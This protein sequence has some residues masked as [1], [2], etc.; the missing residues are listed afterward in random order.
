M[1]TYSQ[2]GKVNKILFVIADYPDKRQDFF[3]KWMSPR[4]REYAEIH[5]FEYRE[6]L[7]L[8]REQDGKF[9]RNNPTWLKFKIVK[10]WIESGELRKGDVISHIDAD[11]CIFDKSKSFETTKSF[12]YAIDSCNTHCMGAYTLRVDDWSI[13]MLNT[14]LSN[15]LYEKCKEE[16]HWKAF[17]EQA[18]WYTMSGIIPHS[19][20][21][22]NSMKNNGFHSSPTKNLKYSLKELE[23]HVEVFPT[24]WNV[25]HVAG[26]GFNDYFMIPTH[27]KDTV[28][29]HF[30]GGGL[31]DESYFVGNQSETTL[32]P[33]HLRCAKQFKLRK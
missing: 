24:E 22:F 30:A 33:S 25:T 10:D 13:E 6:L 4:N 11:I 18:A 29:R 23:K 26:E 19:W 27:R 5:N 7:K 1:Q 31:W 21:P 3:L 17:R 32:E 16:D 28:F 9:F 2:E 20:Q 15:D 8:P 12:G 14:M